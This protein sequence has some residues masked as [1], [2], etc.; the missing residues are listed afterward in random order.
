M[1]RVCGEA[2]RDVKEE[3]LGDGLY[4][5]HTAFGIK[6]RAPREDGDDYVVLE[7]EVFE[8]LLQFAIQIGWLQK[9]QGLK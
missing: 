8:E 7:P 9:G 3:Y 6:L 2:M 5:S 4:A 1:G